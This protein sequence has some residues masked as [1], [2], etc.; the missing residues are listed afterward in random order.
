MARAALEEARA[1]GA[2][3]AIR[4]GRWSGGNGRWACVL[5][6]GAPILWAME[7][8]DVGVVGAGFAGSAAALFLHR[9]GHRVTVY[10]AVED[11]APVGAGIL[12]Q[13]T[14]M[15]VIA[16]LGLLHPVR[17]HGAVVD[18]LRC[19]TRGGRTL[20]DL[21]YG[22]LRGGLHGLG[23][24]RGVL[25][26]VLFD[27]ARAEGVPIR[28]GVH[29]AEIEEGHVVDAAGERHGPH[30]LVV[31]ADGARS[32]IRAA[33]FP[34]VLDAPYPWGALWCVAE[35]PERV[36]ARELFQVVDGTETMLGFLP[37]GFA[38]DG[39][40]P[41]TSFFW[42]LRGDAE[43]R[44]RRAMQLHGL[45]RFK[46]VV[47]AL[48]P[49]SA[50]LLDQLADHGAL[51]FAAYRDVRM[52]RWHHQAEGTRVV[53]IGDA[54]HAMSPQLGQGSNLALY[55]AMG[56]A[57]GLAGASSLAEG[58]Q[59]Y[60]RARESHLRFYGRINRWLTPFFQS[61]GRALGGLRDALFPVVTR[62]PWL[63]RQMV[64]VMAGVRRG[65]VLA[66]PL[67]LPALPPPS[68]ADEGQGDEPGEGAAPRADAD[69]TDA[70]RAAAAE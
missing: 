51:L 60:Q 42:S 32:Q 4:V 33:D 6:G 39:T 40:T 1:E 11:P 30:D 68:Q 50:P 57:D 45:H 63:R 52:R 47:R 19:V 21:P 10:E 7:G 66:D 44:W 61:R 18:R 23:L 62:L 41:L 67:P 55:D 29:V 49:R 46:D 3:M 25:F 37:T 9:A 48:E 27:Q 8:L 24:H 53:F 16:R 35:D 43:P 34:T 12:I 5:R 28:L 17:A 56:L 22:E 64:Q 58:L 26:Q 70:D 14:G 2:H 15:A 36:F 13:P 54:A 65:F 59:A 38:P 20:F 31:V 69:R